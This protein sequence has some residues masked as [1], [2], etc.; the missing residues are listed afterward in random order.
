MVTIIICIK[1]SIHVV[2]I[3]YYTIPYTLGDRKGG[4]K[5]KKGGPRGGGG[6][7]QGG[8]GRDKKPEANKDALDKDMDSCMYLIILHSST[9]MYLY[10]LYIYP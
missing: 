6:K 9:I 1:L 3:A 7:Q 10:L 4:P 8:G 2:F 5:G